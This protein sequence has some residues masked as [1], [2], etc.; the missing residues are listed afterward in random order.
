MGPIP[1]VSMQDL[2]SACKKDST[3]SLIRHEMNDYR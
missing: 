2:E 1:E 3:D